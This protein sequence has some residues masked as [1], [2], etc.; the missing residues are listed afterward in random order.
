MPPLTGGSLPLTNPL[1]PMEEK[2][3]TNPKGWQIALEKR[4]SSFARRMRLGQYWR[5]R[6]DKERDFMTS[7]LQAMIAKNK[8]DADKKTERL[9]SCICSRLPEEIPTGQFRKLLGDAIRAEGQPG[10]KRQV[11]RVLMALRRRG[12]VRFDL[13]SLKWFVAK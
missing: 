6:W 10:D 12:L 7:N 8:D 3:K 13:A 4:K 2:P 1:T 5:Q 11:Q 9:R